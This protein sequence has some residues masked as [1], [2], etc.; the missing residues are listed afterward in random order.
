MISKRIAP[1]FVCLA[2]LCS[3]AFAAEPLRSSEESIARAVACFPD[4]WNRRDMTAFGQCFTTDADFVNVTGQWWKGRVSIERNH[5]FL[6]GTIDQSDIDSVTISTRNYGVFKGTTLTFQSSEL[7]PLRP[8]VVV[9]R[10]S[11][12]ITGDAR[13]PQSRGGLL[14]LVL[15]ATDGV[16]KIAAVQNT[17]IQRPIK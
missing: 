9:A 17:E 14:M 13:T 3:T 4:G 12:Q 16:W 7:R 10:V 2:S 11:W 15:T 5:A 8:D 1:V 6:L